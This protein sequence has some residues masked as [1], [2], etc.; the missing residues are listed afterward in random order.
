MK[1]TMKKKPRA[2]EM[3]AHIGRRL[4]EMRGM[5]N[6]SQEKLAAELGI[7]FQQVQ[8]YENGVNRVAASRLATISKVLKVPVYVF[9]PAEYS[10]DSMGH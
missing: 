7:T 3:D 2:T 6:M 10:V 5:A 8:K 9:F 1:N 4:R